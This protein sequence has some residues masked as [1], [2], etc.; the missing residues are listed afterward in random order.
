MEVLHLGSVLIECIFLFHVFFNRS[1]L[2]LFFSSYC[3]QVFKLFVDLR[4]HIFNIHNLLDHDVPTQIKFD[5]KQCKKKF[6]REELLK[7]HVELN[8]QGYR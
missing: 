6:I 8:H 7:S 5:C 1:N 4:K 2:I 3:D